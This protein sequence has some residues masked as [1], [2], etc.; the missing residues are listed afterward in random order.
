MST[1]PGGRDWGSDIL[2]WVGGAEE[3]D[4]WTWIERVRLVN[5]LE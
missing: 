2:F 3:V 5:V 1:E 4:R